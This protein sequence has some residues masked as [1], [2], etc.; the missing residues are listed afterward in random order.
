[1]VFEAGRV[2]VWSGEWG[3]GSRKQEGGSRLK[4][5]IYRYRLTSPKPVLTPR[6]PRLYTTK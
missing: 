5:E 3:V 6:L 4:A 1:M 2:T